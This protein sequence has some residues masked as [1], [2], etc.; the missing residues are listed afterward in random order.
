MN[1]EIPEIRLVRVKP[2]ERVEFGSPPVEGTHHAVE[3]LVDKN[4]KKKK[5][6]RFSPVN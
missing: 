4:E 2:V 1:T 6:V 3:R 5:R